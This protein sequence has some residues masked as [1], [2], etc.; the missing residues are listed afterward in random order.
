MRST[1]TLLTPPR[2][3]SPA[4]ALPRVPGLRRAWPQEDGSITFEAIDEADG[5]LR[6]GRIGSAG[7][8]SLAP[9]ATDP[10]LPD[11]SPEADG[12]LVVH[13][14]GRRAV[15]IGASRVRKLVRPGRARRLAP[16][17]ALRPFRRAGLR[18][19]EV[20]DRGPSHVSL[21]LLPGRSLHD[22]GDGG[23][24]GWERTPETGTPRKSVRVP[25]SI[26]KPQLSHFMPSQ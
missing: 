12:D 26:S 22:L 20:I 23:M 7:R 4:S 16:P 25:S 10:A 9:Y 17:E 11:L 6:A 2:R 1:L 5:S 15:V 18:T 8:W 19:A 14:L 24:A 3:R 21:E 13:R